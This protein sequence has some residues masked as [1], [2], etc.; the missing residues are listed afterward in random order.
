MASLPDHLKPVP[1][2]RERLSREITAEYQRARVLE[3]AIDLFAKQGYPA[4]T[5]DDLVAAAR[6]G[7]GGFYNQF[8][9]KEQCLLAAHDLIVGEAKAVVSKAVDRG[10]SWTECVC[11]GV[12]GLLAWVA[13]ELV[14]VA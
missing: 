5:V 14:A 11:T 6:I 10:S 1:V 9:G 12:W 3:A 2:G 7:V 13:A 8:A 4:T